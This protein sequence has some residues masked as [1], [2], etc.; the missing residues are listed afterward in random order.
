M[1][2]IINWHKAN[3]ELW[4]YYFSLKWYEDITEALQFDS[5]TALSRKII[6]QELIEEINRI[7]EFN[8]GDLWIGK[9]EI[10]KDSKSRSIESLKKIW[11]KYIMYKNDLWEICIDSID[12][13]EWKHLSA[14]VYRWNNNRSFVLL[15]KT[16]PTKSKLEQTKKWAREKFEAAMM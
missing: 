2:T 15:N 16:K 8:L 3:T 9:Y 7:I 6:P 13:M 1:K 12:T 14:V 5:T 4:N 10:I 11:V